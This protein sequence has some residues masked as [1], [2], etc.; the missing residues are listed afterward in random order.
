MTSPQPGHRRWMLWAIAV[1]VLFVVVAWFPG[2]SPTIRKARS[3]RLGQTQAEVTDA[4]GLGLLDIC[5]IEGQLVM[6]FASDSENRRF[7]IQR[8][9]MSWLAGF[10]LP[11]E[12]LSIEFPVEV[13]LQD[14][15]VT[16]IRRGDER[17]G[18]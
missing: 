6:T 16:Y 10:G 13:H 7:K 8:V 14:D 9:L 4:M 17:L 11:Y 2:E 3:L 18:Q 1:V 5:S 12:F 15:F